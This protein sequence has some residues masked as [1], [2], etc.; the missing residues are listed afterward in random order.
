MLKQKR[1]L[2]TVCSSLSIFSEDKITMNVDGETSIIEG[3]VDFEI[4][5]GNKSG[6]ANIAGTSTLLLR[7]LQDTGTAPC[8]ASNMRLSLPLAHR[9]FLAR[10]SCRYLCIKFSRHS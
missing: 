2:F 7:I 9:G 3:K 10:Q 1:Y 6:P 5:P 8:K 4:I